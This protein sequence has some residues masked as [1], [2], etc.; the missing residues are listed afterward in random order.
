METKYK[1]FFRNNFFLLTLLLVVVISLFL[2]YNRFIAHKD[3]IVRYEGFCDPAVS[4]CFVYCEDDECAEPFYYSWMTKYA[5]D[6]YNQCGSD[7]TD[8]EAA[9]ECFP[10]DRE[11]AIVYCDLEIDGDDCENLTEEELAELAEVEAAEEAEEEMDGV[12]AVEETE[13][14]DG[15]EIV[16]EA[17]E[18]TDEVEKITEEAAEEESLQDDDQEVDQES[19]LDGDNLIN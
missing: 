19:A 1:N 13:G 5:P 3:Y 8:C 9:F 11:C 10:D 17:E 4:D 2:S 15:E 12:A 14:A 6:L 16:E 7:I 18:V